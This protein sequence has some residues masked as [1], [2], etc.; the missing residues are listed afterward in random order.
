[1][2]ATGRVESGTETESNAGAVTEPFSGA[3][4]IL[5]GAQIERSKNDRR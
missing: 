5:P 3:A 2:D 1:M 4:L